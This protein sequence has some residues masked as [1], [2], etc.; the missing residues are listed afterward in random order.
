MNDVP[1][2]GAFRTTGLPKVLVHLNRR[3]LTGVLTVAAADVTKKVFMNKGDAIFATS[4]YDDDRLGEMLIKAGKITVEQYDKSVEM[5]KRTGQRQ[6]AILVKLGFLTPK[7]LFW[8]VKYQ[9][10]EIIQSLFKVEDADYEFVESELPLEEVITL[11]MSM[12]NLIYEGV[13]KIDNWTR[14]RGE[15]PDTESVLQL[16]S[17]PLSLFQDIEL[18]PQ[19]KKIL[20]LID[21]S[22]T[23]KQVIEESWLNSFEALKAL[24]IL[25]SIGILTEK[26]QVGESP[27]SLEDMLIE[28]PSAEEAEFMEKVNFVHAGLKNI[29]DTELLELDESAPLEDIRKSYFRLAKEFHPD[30]F[31]KSRDATLKDKLATI[32]DA[33]TDAYNALKAKASEST[34]EEFEREIKDGAGDPLDTHP[35]IH[36]AQGA[37]AEETVVDAPDDIFDLGAGGGEE[38]E[39][40]AS[41]AARASEAADAYER[42]INSLKNGDL[43]AAV[44]SFEVAT[45]VNPENP[46]YWNYLSLAHSKSAG[47]L[48]E[49]E[50]A[51][52]EAIKLDPSNS[53]YYA[54]FGLLLLKSKDHDKARMQF[55]KSLMLDTD[56]KKALRGLKQIGD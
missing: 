9:V 55:E 36:E 28:A 17:D 3:R 11:K 48:R 30:R 44:V 31:Y 37:Q 5:L 15:M 25:W 21:G 14:I 29:T 26:E 19:D 7:N 27:V 22:K 49:S 23:I 51:M 38:L 39:E 13:K 6:G 12:G 33:V 34:I 4:T 20:A 1:L 47:K 35:E 45:R 53:D 18:S 52:Q 54:N 8:G 2:K 32:F 10:R 46:G 41:E 24:Y 40:M 42:G 43:N 50:A 16:S 56:N